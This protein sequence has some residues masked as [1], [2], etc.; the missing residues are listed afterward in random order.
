MDGSLTGLGVCTLLS[1][2]HYAGQVSLYVCALQGIDCH[3]CK[4]CSLSAAA[5]M[6]VSQAWVFARCSL[7]AS[8]QARSGAELS[9][10]LSVSL[11]L[12][13][14]FASQIAQSKRCTFSGRS[15]SL[16]TVLR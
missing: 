12:P 3:P 1:G 15:T 10:K 6:G 4:A 7:T 16:E 14:L 11:H 2:G 5:W 8:I 9:C 13:T